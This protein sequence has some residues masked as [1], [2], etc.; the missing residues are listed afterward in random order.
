MCFCPVYLCLWLQKW[1][2]ATLPGVSDVFSEVLGPGDPMSAAETYWM[3][4]ATTLQQ[5]SGPTGGC[6]SWGQTNVIQH[7][8]CVASGPH[9]DGSRK[10][11]VSGDISKRG[12]KV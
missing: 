12:G 3:Q 9:G 1:E 10:L 8:L 2:H 4:L 6:R 5:S 11:S 7:V